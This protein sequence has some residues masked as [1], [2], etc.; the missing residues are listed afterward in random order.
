[1]MNDEIHSGVLE[2]AVFAGGRFRDY[3]LIKN[4]LVAALALGVTLVLFSALIFY[5][6][7]SY[8]FE[9]AFLGQFATGVL[10]GVYYVAA[11]G[12]LSFFF[13]A[14]SNV[15]I[16]FVGQVLLLVGLLFTASQ[17][18]GLAERLTASSFP[19]I[20]AKLEFL[21]VSLVFPNII[22]AR[23]NGLFVAGLG[24]ITALL[25]SLQVWKIKSLEM[26]KR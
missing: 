26:R 18:M 24:A 15:L 9:A 4:A 1:M 17:R 10:V 12:I 2:N 22:I 3:L 11:A 21:A 5:G 23:R 19:G 7:V 14:G 13:K 8:Q 20:G 16:I 25:F 6:L